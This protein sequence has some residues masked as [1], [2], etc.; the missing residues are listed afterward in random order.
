[1]LGFIPADL[2]ASVRERSGLGAIDAKVTAAQAAA[3]SQDSYD[4]LDAFR[5]DQLDA[6]RSKRRMIVLTAMVVWA[7]VGAGLGYVWFKRIRW[8]EL[9]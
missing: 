9:D 6:K 8:D 2:V 4:A 1:V 5:A 7:A 3:D